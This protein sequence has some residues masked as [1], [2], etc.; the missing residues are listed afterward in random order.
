MEF[1]SSHFDEYLDRKS[2]VAKANYHFDP[3]VYFNEASSYNTGKSRAPQQV[4]RNP[5]SGVN[6]SKPGAIKPIYSTN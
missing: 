3:N 2:T 6:Y 1:S 5:T 4:I